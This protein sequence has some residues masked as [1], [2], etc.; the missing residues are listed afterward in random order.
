MRSMP[1]YIPIPQEKLIRPSWSGGRSRMVV[2]P[3]GSFFRIPSA[4][5]DDL[6][7]AIG[8]GGPLD[9]DPPGLA[10]RND[11]L[12]GAEPAAADP[13][14]RHS[15]VQLIGCGA[16][17]PGDGRPHLEV[18]GDGD[19]SAIDLKLGPDAVEP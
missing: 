12:G 15:C 10:G 13:H 3:R 18:K 6:A 2:S 7:G 14:S 4:W 8:F 11:Y 17:P 9:G 5:N 19:Q 16:L 1:R